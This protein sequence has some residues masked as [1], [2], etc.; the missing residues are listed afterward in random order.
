MDTVFSFQSVENA[1]QIQ[2]GRVQSACMNMQPGY[3]K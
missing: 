1:I 3:S 2:M